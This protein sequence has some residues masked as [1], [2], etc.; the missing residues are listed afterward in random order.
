M[1]TT[2]LLSMWVV[3]T[4]AVAMMLPIADAVLRE[5][6]S[7]KSEPKIANKNMIEMN[8]Y[9]NPRHPFQKEDKAMQMSVT[10]KPDAMQFDEKKKRQLS[11][12]LYLSI[13]FSSTI[14]GVSTL[15]SNGPNLIMKFVLDEY[16]LP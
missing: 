3:T 13:A 7:E 5:I 16:V 8:G 14:G 12:L 11:V 15:T 10:V 6:F 2:T 1:L 9:H 4:A